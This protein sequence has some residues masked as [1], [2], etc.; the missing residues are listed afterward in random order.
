MTIGGVEVDVDSERVQRELETLSSWS[1]AEPPAVTRVVF[2]EEDLAARAFVKRLCHEA[3]LVVREDPLG[4]TFARWEGLRPEPPAIATGSHIDAIPGAGRY[5][6]TVGVLGAIEAVRALK[7]AGFRPDRSIE[8]IIFTSEEPTRFGVGCLGSRVM[9]GALSPAALAALRDGSGRTLDEVR[10]AAGFTGELEAVR[11]PLGHYAAFVELHIEQGQLLER[12]GLPIGVVTA[13][14]AP[15]TLRV[16]LVGIGGHAGTVLMPNRRDALCGAAEVIL[17][18]EA[19]A[20]G[21]GSPDAVATTGVCRV[22]PGAVNGIPA[23]STLEIDI[24]D[25]DPEPRDRVVAEV[26]DAVATIAAR[27]GLRAEVGVLNLDPPARADPAVVGAVE[28]ACNDLGLP[29]LRMVSRAYHDA[30]FMARPAPAGMIF[31]PCKGGV[32]HRPEEY[33]SP[34]EIG[35]GIAVLARTIARLSSEVGD[36]VIPT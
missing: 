19:A 13:I 35:Q 30:L 29:F 36:R 26:R 3:G 17:T 16:E 5:D 24:R 27:R 28:S 4:N 8:L 23:R 18:V 25:I 20:R 22:D 32:S 10:L 1:E 34:E 33:S 21:C 14:A 9:S 6:G 7:R 12:A 31:I 15:A 2:T 11:L